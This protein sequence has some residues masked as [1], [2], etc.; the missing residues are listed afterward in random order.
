MK[1]LI[2]LLLISSILSVPSLASADRVISVSPEKVIQGDPVMIRIMGTASS[3]PVQAISF[4]GKKLKVFSYEN[5]PTALVP[6]DLRAKAGTSTVRVVFVDGAVLTKDVVVLERE[7]KEAPFGIPAS[8]GG[9]TATSAAKLVSTL[10]DESKLLLGLRTGTHA[11]WKEPFRFPVANPVVTDEYGY[12]RDTIGYSIPHKGTDFRAPVGTPVMAM[13]RGV[14]RLTKNFR[15]YGK[16]IV[17]DH[18]FGLMTFYMHLSK[19]RVNV[20]ELV[21]PGQVI[22]LSGDTGYAEGAHLHLTVRI[23]EVS[24]DP[25]VFMGFFK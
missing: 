1:R 2:S 4:S 21:L 3:S 7:K 18:G 12:S 6:I 14:V 24:I 20:G 25:M 8:L 13:N 22:G 10:V 15:N 17:V 23:N 16:T 11:F 19:I 5:I 9:N